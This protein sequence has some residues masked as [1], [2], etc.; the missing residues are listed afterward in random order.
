MMMLGSLWKDWK[1][2]PPLLLILPAIL[3]MGGAIVLSQTRGLWGGILLALAA[4][5]ILNLFRKDPGVRLG[6]KMIISIT[7][8]AIFIGLVVMTV[9]TL[10]IISAADIAERTGNESGSYITDASVMSRLLSWLAVIERLDSSHALLGRGLGESITYFKPEV[11]E[12]RTMTFVDSSYFQ[13]ALVM[14][15]T[16]VIFLIGLF[17]SAL[18]RSAKLFLR[19]RSSSRAGRVLGIFC[20]VVMLLFASGFASPLTNYRFTILW[21]FILALLQ[22]EIILDRRPTD[23]RTESETPEVS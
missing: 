10:G 8:L 21:A 14:G 23:D 5:W 20:A 2:R 1:R 15:V 7:V 9:S 4:A 11:G 16:G 17:I 19:T 22:T 18:I 6:R 12:V 13:T 3:V